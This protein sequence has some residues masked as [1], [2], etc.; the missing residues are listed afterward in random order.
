MG[1]LAVR[2]YLAATAEREFEGDART[3]RYALT[4]APEIVNQWA[5]P[6]RSDD[7]YGRITA[8]VNLHLGPAIL[9][10]QGSTTISNDEG[11]D[12]Y[13]FLALRLNL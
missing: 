3:I 1:G 6:Q 12:V 4:A 10:V 13:G 7:I 8:G 5:L 11:N 2:P 9:Q